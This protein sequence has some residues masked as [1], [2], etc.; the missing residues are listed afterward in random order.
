MP[1]PAKKTRHGDDLVSQVRPAQHSLPCEGERAE[2][3]EA[4]ANLLRGSA[5]DRTEGRSRLLS[6]TLGCGCLV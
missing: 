5:W 2:P 1:T 3:H 4:S 6:L